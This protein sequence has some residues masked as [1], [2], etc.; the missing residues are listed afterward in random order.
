M[1]FFRVKVM[2]TLPHP[3]RGF[4]QGL[5]AE[6]ETVWESGG[7]YGLS[8]LR[9][10]ELGAAKVAAEADVAAGAIRRGNLPG[11]RE[12]RAAHLARA[13]RPALGC[14]HP[15]GPEKVR[16]NREGWGICA[17]PVDKGA[18][19]CLGLWISLWMKW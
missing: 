12:H 8:V 10:Y 6:G 2:R 16:F 9:R 1:R 3:G 14:P 4:T 17:V 13:R 5:I 18:S 19:M 15:G 11:G 7:Q